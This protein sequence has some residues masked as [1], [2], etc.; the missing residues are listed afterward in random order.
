MLTANVTTITFESE[1]EEVDD[2]DALSFKSVVPGGVTYVKSYVNM[3][4]QRI[5]KWTLSLKYMVIE[6]HPI[7][8][9]VMI[10][11][12]L[13]QRCVLRFHLKVITTCVKDK[14]NS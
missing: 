11:I 1:L 2:N 3:H 6:L 9:L 14:A 12:P 8:S 4:E 10:N 7:L 13:S 5:F